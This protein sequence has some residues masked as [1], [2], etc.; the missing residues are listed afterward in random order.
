MLVV[1]FSFSELVHCLCQVFA[2]VEV[3]Q[4]KDQPRIFTLIGSSHCSFLIW[5][6]CALTFKWH[7]T[8]WFSLFLLLSSLSRLLLYII[9]VDYVLQLHLHLK[10]CP[11]ELKEQILIQ[12]LWEICTKCHH[13]CLFVKIQRGNY[14]RHH[15][16]HSL[17]M[18]V[19]MIKWVWM[20]LFL[21]EVKFS[22]IVMS[23][24]KWQVSGKFIPFENTFL[25]RGLF[26][27]LHTACDFY[28]SYKQVA[29][30]L[31]APNIACNR[32]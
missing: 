7:D 8:L 17:R 30:N 24:Q 11:V 1:V 25:L 5:W 9:A 27:V 6:Y 26:T 3:C 19:V 29:G 14:G 20:T 15:L 16:Y 31:T 23:L 22:A 13:L 12:K 32:Y 10:M 21:N 28:C 18:N 2:S 4:L